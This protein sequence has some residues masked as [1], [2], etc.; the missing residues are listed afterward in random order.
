MYEKCLERDLCREQ[1]ADQ[2]TLQ[3]HSHTH[4]HIHTLF[5]V[6]FKLSSSPNILESWRMPLVRVRSGR[7]SFFAE[8]QRRRVE[9][10]VRINLMMIRGRGVLFIFIPQLM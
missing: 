9:F 1:M 8:V 6:M 10:T 4:T 2:H 7:A 5:W 3:P